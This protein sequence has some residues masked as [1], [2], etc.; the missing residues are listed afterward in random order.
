MKK[1]KLSSKFKSCPSYDL[2]VQLWY[3][4]DIYLVTRIGAYIFFKYYE[5]DVLKINLKKNI[6]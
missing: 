2:Y 5:W 3:T 4:L 6:V 1:L